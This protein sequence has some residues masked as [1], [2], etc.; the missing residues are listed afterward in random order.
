[1]RQSLSFI[2]FISGL[3]LVVHPPHGRA[4][5]VIG[6]MFMAFGVVFAVEAFRRS[7][8]TPEQSPRADEG[9]E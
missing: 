6:G 7:R 4:W 5:D 2:T 3:L 1:V 8:A 9:K